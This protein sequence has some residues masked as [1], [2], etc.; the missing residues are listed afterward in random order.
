VSAIAALFNRDG[1]LVDDE[2]LAAFH[3]AGEHRAVD[4][5]QSWSHGSVGLLHQHFTLWR[6]DDVAYQ[7]LATSDGN[8]VVVGD[9]RLDARSEIC[10]RLAVDSGVPQSDPNLVLRAY[11]K[12]G[13]GCAEHLRGDFAFAVW[14]EANRCLFCAR[15]ALGVRDLAYFISDGLFVAASEVAQV[16]AH[17]DVPRRLNEGRLAEFLANAWHEHHESFFEDVFFCPPG[18]CLLVTESS[19]R[20]WRYWNID[21]GRQ[22][23][24][25]READYAE[26]F[27]DLLMDAVRDRL[28]STDAVAV[29]LSG[30]PDSA[31]L[32][33][34]ASRT[35]PSAPVK[36][37]S[38]IFD[39]F[40]SCDERR[41]IQTVV[42]RFGLDATFISG[43]ELWPLK[44]LETWPIFP[45]FPSQDPYVRL[46]IAI[47][48]A[49][50]DAGC[51]VILNGHFSDLL[52]HGGR[53][54]AA[55]LLSPRR[56][57]E[58]VSTIAGS[59]QS[60]DWGRDLI[61]NGVWMRSPRWLRRTVRGL[62][63]S[64]RLAR[65]RAM[66]EPTF[67]EGI[68]LAERIR[69]AERLLPGA[70]ADFEARW[71]HLSLSVDEQGA[72]SARRLYNRRG[73]ELVDPFWDRRLVEYVMAIPAHLL[74]RPGVTKYL[75]RRATAGVVPDE[76]RERPDKTS[77]YELFC[78]GLLRRERNTVDN[79]LNRPG[80][81]ERGFVRES[82]LTQE[83]AAGEEWTDYGHPLWRC[84]S[85]ELWLRGQQSFRLSVRS[86][87]GRHP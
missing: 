60:V 8:H 54:M 46:P 4:G 23:V 64:D 76:V 10:D 82:W 22:I 49:A 1:M 59:W 26:E 35:R 65:H 56:F 68:D 28:R 17:P 87:K 69:R 58:V 11:R 50:R 25:R 27:R 79:L 55:D 13:V 29:S 5:H 84:L 47:A 30:G 52:F 42:D 66:L 9:T 86:D 36:S 78:E 2:V 71:R 40:E 18:H 37:F 80:I 83:L 51:R 21:P 81:V 38:Y 19:F 31:A 7:P 20:L 62:R 67:V 24:Y 34:I 14:D 85:V 43:D 6:D 57:L 53:F 77:L 41:Y 16:L 75:L 44:D 63:S 72:A 39:R 48:D 70:S 74:A 12:W 73:T 33:A 61:R 3:L 45:D 32:A 15:D